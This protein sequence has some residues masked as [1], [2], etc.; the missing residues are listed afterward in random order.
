MANCPICGKE[1]SQVLREW[2]YGCFHVK[3]FSC[4]KCRKTFRVYYWQS[5]VSHVISVHST[6]RSK[7]LEYLK[8]HGDATEFA[9]AEAFH[10]PV[11]DVLNM[12]EKLEK[13]GTVFQ[14]WSN[15]AK[16]FG[17][18][19]TSFSMSK[20]VKDINMP[21]VASIIVFFMLFGFIAV[22]I[23][24]G[25]AEL[26]VIAKNIVGIQN[27]VTNPQDF[28]RLTFATWAIFLFISGGM[29][30]VVL[31]II[32][33]VSKRSENNPKAE[34]RIL[35]SVFLLGVVVI[36]LVLGLDWKWLLSVTR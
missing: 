23:G 31:D 8:G 20:Q 21:N 22:L 19:I 6:L 4:K 34:K 13:E 35:L 29:F 9:I 10:L 33:E 24:F 27:Y 7:I 3:N 2:D 1:C 18:E 32:Q 12:L 16:L 17:R 5:R 15:D 11:K 30:A 36:A 28:V 25:C 14:T 26:L